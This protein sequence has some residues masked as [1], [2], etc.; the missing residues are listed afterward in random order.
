MPVDVV[1]SAQTA[2]GPHG[3]DTVGHLFY[4]KGAD[5]LNHQLDEYF[6]QHPGIVALSG[7]LVKKGKPV[8][9][10]DLR[11]RQLFPTFQ[12]RR[13]EVGFAV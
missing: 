10:R 6:G 7:T 1:H 12:S 3:Q 11:F 2:T 13:F 8:V 9:H 4:K 5:H